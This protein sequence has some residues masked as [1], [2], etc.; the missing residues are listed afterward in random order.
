MNSPK[1]LAMLAYK[2]IS[3]SDVIKRKYSNTY[4]YFQNYC[5]TI[6]IDAILS[7]N[8]NLDLDVACHIYLE[9][10]NMLK[11]NH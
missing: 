3:A 1:F 6:K 10:P 4:L 11:P 8:N 5:N 7:I 9:I 2:N